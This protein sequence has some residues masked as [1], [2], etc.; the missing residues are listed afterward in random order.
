MVI[1][2]QFLSKSPKAQNL[3]PIK[4][5]VLADFSLQFLEP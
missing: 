5:S 4:A 3:S 2:F 1:E